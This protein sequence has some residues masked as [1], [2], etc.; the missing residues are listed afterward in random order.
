VDGGYAL[1]Y[2]IF[3]RFSQMNDFRSL[4]RVRGQEKQIMDLLLQFAIASAFDT[5]LEPHHL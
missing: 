2:N 4:R 3:N 1:D 5:L